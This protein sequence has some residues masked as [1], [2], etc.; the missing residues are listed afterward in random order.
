MNK[1]SMMTYKEFKNY[2][3]ERVCDG[4]WSMEEAI[5]CIS[6]IEE[7]D[8]IKEK[9]LGITLRKKTEKVREEAWQR[10]IKK[11]QGGN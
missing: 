7:I 3:N 2:C 5:L 9:I 1:F 10:I 4:R 11:L 8:D 6:I